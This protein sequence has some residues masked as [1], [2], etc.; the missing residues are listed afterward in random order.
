MTYNSILVR[1][2]IMLALLSSAF[3]FPA[4]AQFVSD[5]EYRAQAGL[6]T[7]R[8]D[9]AYSLGLSGLGVKVGIVDTGI[10]PN[11]REFA[12]AISSGY[13]FIIGSPALT[14]TSPDFH[15]SHV[16]GI[17]GARRDGVGMHGVAYNTSLV[18]ARAVGGTNNMVASAMDFTVAN[19]ARVM[20][21]S[22]GFSTSIT[23]ITKDALASAIP[24]L[25]LSSKNAV[26]KDTVV[27]F[28]TG[29]NSFLQPD[30]MAGLPYYYPELL[31][32]WIA[33]A[34]SDV[35]A[36]FMSGYSNYCGVAASWCITAPGGYIPVDAGIYSVDGATNS[37]YKSLQGTSMAA[38][39]VS[40]AV[41][42]V[43]ERFP[44]MTGAQLA[45]TVLTTGTFAAAP[46]SVSGRGLLDVGKAVGGPGI[47]ETVFSANT[48][49]LNSTFSNNI[50]GTGSLTKSGAGTLTLSGAN[51]YSGATTINA[52]TL[53][54]NGSIVSSV[55]VASGGTLNGSGTVG[56]SSISNGATIAPGNSIGLLTINGNVS[57]AAGSIYEVEV[58]NTRQA[59]RLNA[60][61]AATINGGTVHV[62]TQVRGYTAANTYTI[63]SATGGVAGTFNNVIVDNSTISNLFFM[64]GSVGYT[65][66]VASLTIE[67]IA[68]FKNIART[69]NE[70]SSA[71][72]MQTGGA[73]G[74]ELYIAILNS[75]SDANAQAAF[76]PASGEIHATLLAGQFE[77]AMSTRR[78][79]LD[80][81][82]R[83]N[84]TNSEGWSMWGQVSGNWGSLDGDGNAAGASRSGVNITLGGDTRLDEHWR[85]GLEGGYSSNTL[86][87]AARTSSADLRAGHIGAYA[88]G[89]Y[90]AYV[91]RAGASY[92]FGNIRTQRSI[93][94][95][96][97]S[98]TASASQDANMLQ[99]F[100]EVGYDFTFDNVTLE[101]FAGL[102]WT[103]VSAGAFRENGGSAAL[104]GKA[105]DMDN[106]Y[107]TMGTQVFT[108]PI[109][110]AGATLTPLLRAGWQHAFTLTT[111]S[112]SMTFISTGQAFTVQGVPLDRDRALL[113]VGATLNLDDN[114][115]ITLGYAG[116]LGSHANDNSI[117]LTGNF[118]L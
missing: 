48:A 20:N 93:D 9:A 86:Q 104:M 57:F 59:D 58:N 5:A 103:Q 71:T 6:A 117:R 65:S 23:S 85:G 96:G 73:G 66:S 13:D 28:A 79:V 74:S 101:P 19:G 55:T 84:D 33:V 98:D 63:L 35:N 76:N 64:N 25:I 99:M 102:A 41:A 22:W 46:N 52:G 39:M 61:G 51:T 1:R 75:T 108:T 90:D 4:N 105:R 16:A 36:K 116:A 113:D 7:V 109:D 82:R 87:V 95:T 92:G 10:N 11:H 83:Q 77:N 32:N 45:S 69:P 37:D 30:V 38:P 2:H 78:T 72:A 97:F 15:G 114:T 106:G 89:S 53:S 43:A 12:R 70:I 67:Q 17:I 42:L 3:S 115:Q 18:I 81:M 47:F 62:L 54:V 94:F 8:A 107:F 112:R 56:S 50:S 44:W 68:T 80:R 14:D 60:T 40:G 26:S 100:G 34:A 21:N 118:K 49:G 24:S 27:V 91:L 88:F 29:N 110:F 111:L 31:P